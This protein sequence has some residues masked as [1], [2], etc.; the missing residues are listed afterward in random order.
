MKRKRSRSRPGNPWVALDSL[1][2]NETGV[3][4]HMDFPWETHGSF[5]VMG[6]HPGRRIRLVRRAPLGDPIEV[7][8]LGYRLAL[9]AQEARRIFVKPCPKRGRP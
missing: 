7:E 8:L 2:E 5:G 3:L 4:H 6:F 9:R 1:L